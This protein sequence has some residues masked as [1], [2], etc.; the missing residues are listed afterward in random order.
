MTDLYN[1]F[2]NDWNN[3]QK[4]KYLCGVYYDEH[5]FKPC[6]FPFKVGMLPPPNK[7]ITIHNYHY[8]FFKTIPSLSEFNINLKNLI[9]YIKQKDIENDFKF[10]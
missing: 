1:N 4:K 3:V 10:D 9:V 2:I 7:P 5:N 6:I 8:I